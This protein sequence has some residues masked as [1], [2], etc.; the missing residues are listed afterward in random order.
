ML[1]IIQDF[2]AISF[3][4]KVKYLIGRLKEKDQCKKLDQ[5]AHALVIHAILFNKSIDEKP[6]SIH[7]T[8]KIMNSKL[9]VETILLG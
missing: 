8:K 9:F 4:S 2:T 7:W 1:L 5:Y 6:I 3:F